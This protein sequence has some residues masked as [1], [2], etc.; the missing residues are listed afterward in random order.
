[1]QWN[2]KCH[3]DADGLDSCCPVLQRGRNP[4]VGGWKTFASETS[5]WSSRDVNNTQDQIFI[6]DK[7]ESVTA[8]VTGSNGIGGNC[9]KIVKELQPYCPSLLKVEF[10]NPNSNVPL[11][12]EPVVCDNHLC[13]IALADNSVGLESGLCIIRWNQECVIEED[14]RDRCCPNISKDYRNDMVSV[15]IDDFNTKYRAGQNGGEFAIKIFANTFQGPSATVFVTSR[16][17]PETDF[18]VINAAYGTKTLLLSVQSNSKPMPASIYKD[19]R[20]SMRTFEIH[21]TPRE[22]CNTVGGLGFQML[23]F[24]HESLRGMWVSLSVNNNADSLLST[25]IADD[26]FYT[27]HGNAFLAPISTYRNDLRH[28]VDGLGFHELEKHHEGYVMAEEGVFRMQDGH[29]KGLTSNEC[30]LPLSMDNRYKQHLK[31]FASQG[32]QSV[33]PLMR[34]RWVKDWLPVN[35]KEDVPMVMYVT[36]IAADALPENSTTKGMFIVKYFDAVNATWKSLSNCTDYEQT[37]QTITCFM[38]QSFLA[39]RGM[40][41]ILALLVPSSST[42]GLALSLSESRYFNRQGLSYGYDEVKY[43]VTTTDAAA[44]PSTTPTSS[45]SQQQEHIDFALVIVIIVS[46]I[47]LGASLLVWYTCT[48]KKI[49]LRSTDDPETQ[50]HLLPAQKKELP[51]ESFF[52][53]KISPGHARGR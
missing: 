46:G 28:E 18:P 22:S 33:G 51:V 40:Q 16:P 47:G 3:I 19:L 4:P 49:L 45:P 32:F 36:S 5:A 39:S 17:D 38:E 21:H 30:K 25:V 53:K 9:S 44:P 15:I 41:L 52:A 6:Y 48:R 43:S 1:M 34:R 42:A 31:N 13:S 7:M 24:F 20:I 37:T 26:A 27:N 23:F 50:E 11:V 2:H 12:G 10:V 29:F 8:V 35:S 14:G